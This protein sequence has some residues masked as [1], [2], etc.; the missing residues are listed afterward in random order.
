MNMWKNFFNQVLNIHGVHDVRHMDIHTV[1]PLVPESHLVEVEIAIGKLKSYKSPGTDQIPAE[2]IKAGVK[3]Y[4][5]RYTNLFVPYGIRRNWHSSGRNLLLY[6]FI[7]RVIRLIVIIIEESPSY[8]LST[9]FYPTFFWPGYFHTSVKLLGII[10]VCFVVT[11]TTDQ[12]FYIQLILEKKWECNGTVH[13]LFIDFKKAYDSFKR[14]VLY[15]NLVEFGAPKKLVRL[16]KMCLNETYSKVRV[17]KLLSDKFPLQNG[18]KQGDALSP[19]LF[20]FALD[21][22]IR[23]V[24]EQWYSTGGTRRHL[25]GYVKFKISIYILF[26]E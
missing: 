15:N 21:Y 25:R 10:S 13:Q 16:I 1:E 7:R 22:T 6:Q 26:H 23:N 12:I 5:L 4:I 9:K 2:L 17:G 8:Q 11:S 24:L 19:L 18:L 3:Y 20:D 14:E